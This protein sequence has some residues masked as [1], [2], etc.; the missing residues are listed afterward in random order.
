MRM[1]LLEAAARLLALEGPGA[2]SARRAARE[3]GA[4]TMVVYT[5]FGGMK[6]LVTAVVR[7]GFARL[8]DLVTA[9]PRTDDPVA[10]LYAMLGAYR[11]TALANPHLYAVMFG[12]A[13]WAATEYRQSAHHGPIRPSTR[14]SKPRV[15]R[16]PPV[17]STPAIR[18]LPRRNSGA[19]RTASRWSRWLDTP[20]TTSAPPGNCSSR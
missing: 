3:V 10:D 14:S 9:V 20:T 1:R 16:S 17:A 8:A 7:E 13:P 6:E 12:S 2:L 19:R 5:H 18:S 11:R 4:S 15:A